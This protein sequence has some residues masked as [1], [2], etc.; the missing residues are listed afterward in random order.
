MWRR[1]FVVA[2]FALM[3][4]Q[5]AGATS[6]FVGIVSSVSDAG[7]A[8]HITMRERRAET[9]AVDDKTAYMKWIMHKPFQQDQRAGASALTV[10]RCVNV[11][12]RSDGA[13]LA[14]VIWIS[15]EGEGT[16][17]DPCKEIR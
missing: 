2:G 10:G 16:V 8:V 15:T 5:G 14:K 13:N 4:V 9:V 3:T 1:T 12:L 6:R 7:Q 11:D 17:W